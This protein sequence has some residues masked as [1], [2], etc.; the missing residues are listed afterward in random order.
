V[1]PG[2]PDQV[3]RIEPPLPALLVELAVVPIVATER[4]RPHRA[5]AGPRW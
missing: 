4:D 3:E 1:V 5:V 2:D